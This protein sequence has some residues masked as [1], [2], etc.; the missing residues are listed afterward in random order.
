MNIKL[1][2][3]WFSAIFL[4][5]HIGL[6]RSYPIQQVKINNCIVWQEICETTLPRIQNAD[7]DRYANDPLYRRIYTVLRWATYIGQWDRWV[8]SHKGVDIASVPKTPVYAI[9]QWEVIEAWWRWNRWNV[10]VIKHNDNW[11]TIHSSYAHLWSM[12][13]NIWDT[14]NE[15][16]I[17]GEIGD[18]GNASWPHVHFQIDT[19]D[20]WPYPFHMSNCSWSLDDIVNN[21]LCRDQLI[22]NTVDPIVFL[23]EKINGKQPTTNPTI[24]FNNFIG[25]Y[26]QINTLQFLNIKNTNLDE[27]SSPISIKFDTD[28]V[29][30]FPTQIDFLW[31]QRTIY[32]RGIQ[33]WFT[34][35]DFIQN[36]TVI[37]R[38]PL[39]VWEEQSFRV[40]NDTITSLFEKIPLQ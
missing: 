24:Q 36:N 21:G 1:L 4:S 11:K 14:V 18:S 31:S 20:K 23:E 10:I 35:I 26:S 28:K 13:V 38:I 6:A 37:K 33:T 7:Y 39:I 5:I 19:T 8:W 17:I 22:K 32:L 29:W 9:H 34:T 30:I 16:Q 3:W 2:L 40:D 25:G 27:I 15:Q 12:F